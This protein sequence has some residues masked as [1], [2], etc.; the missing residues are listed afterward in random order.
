[1]LTFEMIRELERQERANKK[2]QKLPDNLLD[3]LRDYIKR[4]ESMPEKSS[5]DILELENVKTIIKRFFELRESKI[6]DI[7]LATART[8]LPPEHLTK[9]E[10]SV[11]YSIVDSVKKHREMF[12]SEIHKEPQPKAAEEK[13]QERIIYRVKKDLQD[14]VGPD[15]KTYRLIRGEIVNLPKPLNDLLLKEGVIEEIKE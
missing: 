13:K 6:M 8:G 11:F 2:L 14:F 3:E 7:A 4:K 9:E 12:F 5:T 1:M 15:M 10:Q